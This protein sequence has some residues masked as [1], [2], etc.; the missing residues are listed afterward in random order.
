MRRLKIIMDKIDPQRKYITFH[1]VVPYE[2][3]SEF[4]GNADAGLFASSYENTPNILEENMSTG[5][6]NRML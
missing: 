4:Y 3:F 1:G 2:K 6:A 5:F